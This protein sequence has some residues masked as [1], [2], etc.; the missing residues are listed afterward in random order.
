M[1]IVACLDNHNGMFFSRKRQSQDYLQRLDLKDLIKEEELYMNSYSFRLYQ[2]VFL[3]QCIV[4]ESFLE[5]CPNG[6][7]A[8]V[9]TETFLP[10]LD[11]IEEC[12]FYFWNRH[13]P[14]D[15]IIDLQFLAE[16]KIVDQKEFLGSSHEKITRIIYRRK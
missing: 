7:Y 1:K 6:K 12:I 2:D 15:S 8:L 14:S 13:Y 9:E 3:N 11:K 5:E 10:Y 16:W 4:S